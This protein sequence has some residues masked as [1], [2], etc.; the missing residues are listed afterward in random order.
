[1]SLLVT[2]VALDLQN[3][4]HF[5]LNGA[6]INTR[7]RGVVAAALSLS[8]LLAPRIL[9]LVILVLLQVD[10][11]ICWVEEDYFLLDVS[12]EGESVDLFFLLESFSSFI[13][14]LFFL[15]YPESMLRVL[16][17]DWSI[18]FAFALTAFSTTSFQEF[19]S[20]ARASNW[21][22][23]EGFRSFMK[24]WIMISSFGVAKDQ[25]LGGPLAYAP[26]GLAG[27]RFPP[28]GSGSPSWAFPSRCPHRL[29][30]HPGFIGG[31]PWTCLM[32]LRQGFWRYVSTYTT[33]SGSWSG[34]VEKTQQKESR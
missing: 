33:A 6:C 30:S 20:W 17:G 27:W 9:L 4:C 26:D 2:I 16:E 23:I 21:A 25:T 19:R 13:V 1:M 12:A 28:V 14:G 34:P 22:R 3:I 24:H 7:C 15:G 29:I 5:F 32:W 11:E 18:T 31:M 8:A 10:G